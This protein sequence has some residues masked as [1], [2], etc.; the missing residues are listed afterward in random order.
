[1]TLLSSR[2]SFLCRRDSW[3]S[4]LKK[5]TAFLGTASRKHTYQAVRQFL[6]DLQ[7]LGGVESE[8]VPLSDYQIGICR[9]CKLCFE[10]GEAACPLKDDRDVL[11]EK[12]MASDGVIFATP[13]LSWQ[14]SGLMKVF[15]DRLGYSLHRPRFFGKTFT[16]IVAQGIYGGHKIVSYLDFMAQTLGFNTVKGTYFTAFDPMTE[17]ERQRSAGLLAKQSRQFHKSLMGPAFPEPSMLM[18]LGFR[19]GRT[20]I[21]LELDDRSFDYRYYRD[22]GWLESDYFYPTRLNP[23]KK[24]AGKL[25]ESVQAGRTRRRSSSPR[26]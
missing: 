16:S 25:S 26:V 11:V 18:L 2:G 20:S 4:A 23:I 9:T 22:K 7:S 17:K 15:L 12:M 19:M 5:V 21:R 1:M 10:K 6:D 3:R 24:A 13:N 14:V 8:I